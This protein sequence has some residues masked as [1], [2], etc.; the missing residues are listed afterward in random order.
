MF[1]V[2][3]KKQRPKFEA[4]LNQTVIDKSNTQLE[5]S[6]RYSLLAPGK[7][8]RPLLILAVLNAFD[9]S[10]EIGYPVATALEMVHAYSLIHDDLP[11]MDNDD[12]RRG[13]PTNHKKFN[14]AT[15]ILAGDALLTEAFL[16]LTLTKTSHSKIVQLVR[17]LS[18]TAGYC[19]MV[20]GQQADINA[21]GNAVTL[22]QLQSIHIRKTGA[23]LRFAL[24]AGSILADQSG[25]IC[26]MFGILGLELGLAYQIR[27]DI[28]D[29]IGTEELIGKPIGSDIKEDKSTYPSLLGLTEAKNTF[30]ASLNS[31][32]KNIENI[33]QAT[34]HFK[35]DILISFIEQLS[36]EDVLYEE[37]KSG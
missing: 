22:Q 3:S 11:D 14:T 31:C 36:L 16:Q 7:R 25:D 5:E 30:K 37:T 12:L 20:G 28:L 8:L 2:F 6:M 9:V 27:D 17:L 24:V 32:R 4:Y 21:T 13:L 33:Y 26:D 23:L 1:L 10:V 34:N 29:V 35:R 15:A 19:G 18:E